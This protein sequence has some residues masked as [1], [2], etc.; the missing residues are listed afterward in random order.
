MTESNE[1]MWVLHMHTGSGLNMPVLSDA[2]V[3]CMLYLTRMHLKT[4]WQL[5]E[6]S[7]EIAQLVRGGCIWRMKTPQLGLR[8]GW[9]GGDCEQ[10]HTTQEKTALHT[11]LTGGWRRVLANEMNDSQVHDLNIGGTC[12]AGS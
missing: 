9:C 12:V 6:A 1:V 8:C 2:Q 5:F 3:V 7:V 10:D 4:K 11:R